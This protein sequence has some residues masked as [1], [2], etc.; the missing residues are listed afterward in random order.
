[1]NLIKSKKT[2]QEDSTLRYLTKITNYKIG[3]GLTLGTLDKPTTTWILSYN[4]QNESKWFCEGI[5]TFFKID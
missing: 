4:K 2:V 3:G 5:K 1:M